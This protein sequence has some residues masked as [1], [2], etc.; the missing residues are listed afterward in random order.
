MN[1]VD[2][3][4][5]EDFPDFKEIYDTLMYAKTTGRA[6][7][8]DTMPADISFMLHRLGYTFTKKEHL[9]HYH[10]MLFYFEGEDGTFQLDVEYWRMLVTVVFMPKEK[11]GVAYAD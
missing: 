11:V 2:L 6:E 8:E 1:A 5:W 3:I 10:T 9:E 7:F 4:K